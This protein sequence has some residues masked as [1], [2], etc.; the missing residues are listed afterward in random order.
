MLA[1]SDDPR[2]SMVTES[3]YSAK[4]IAVC[5]AEFPPPTRCTVRPCTSDASL[6]AAP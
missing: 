3:A 4:N 5:P 6:G 2:T 1:A